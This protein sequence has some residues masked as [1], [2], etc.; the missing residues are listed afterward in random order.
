MYNIGFVPYY[1]IDCHIIGLVLYWVNRL[2]GLVPLYR[3]CQL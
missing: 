3:V 2:I 1:S